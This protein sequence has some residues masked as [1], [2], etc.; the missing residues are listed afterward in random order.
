MSQDSDAS[1][2]WMMLAL[3]RQNDRR[4]RVLLETS[5]ALV[6]VGVLVLFRLPRLPVVGVRRFGGGALLGFGGW[7]DFAAHRAWKDCAAAIEGGFP[8]APRRWPRGLHVGVEAT[9]FV[10]SVLLLFAHRR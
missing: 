4:Q 10:A 9:F 6:A 7:L 8:Q 1:R 2:E 5:F 3:Q